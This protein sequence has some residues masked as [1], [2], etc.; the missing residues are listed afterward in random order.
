MWAPRMRK[1]GGGEGKK[2]GR[3]MTGKKRLARNAMYRITFL[4]ETK[5][6]KR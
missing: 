3:Q 5:N 1:E 4:G 6:T 2:K